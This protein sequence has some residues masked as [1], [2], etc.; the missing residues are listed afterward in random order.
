MQDQK[1]PCDIEAERAIL[2]AILV[3]PD[4]LHDVA[5]A[6]APGDFFRHGHR[7]VYDA[8]RE[9]AERRQA[10]DPLTVRAALSEKALEDAGGPIYIFGLA[11]GVP[12]STNVAAYCE[13]VKGAALR[14]RLQAIAT[15]AIAEAASSDIDAAAAVERAERA[16]YELGAKTQSGDLVP[17]EAAIAEVWPRIAEVV[18]T[19]RPQTGIPTGY[20]DLDRMTRGMF[21]G[22]LIILAARPGMGKSA[23]ALNVAHHVANTADQTVAFFSLEMSNDEISERLLGAVGRVN[24]HRVMGG[25][26][27]DEDLERLGLARGEAAASSLYIDDTSAQTVMSIRG[28]ARR[29][30]ARKGLGLVVVDYLQLLSSERRYDS[31]VVEVGAMSRGLK[32]LAGELEVPI[33]CLSQLNR[34]SEGRAESKPRISD[35]RE[36]G[37]LEQDANQVW[38]L[39]RPEAYQATPENTGLAELIVGKNRKGPTGTVTLRWAK[40]ETRFDSL[41]DR[42]E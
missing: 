25:R 28:K 42:G 1:T 23:L 34:A 2:G 16:I 27:F 14:R 15:A 7:I 21:P 24:M 20:P 29:L 33:L 13:I 3:N 17:I 4:L 40:D 19:G 38:L 36:S 12:R 6:I 11:D 35:L 32:Q 37:S 5:A 8:M 18:D 30:K 22:N 10:I 31:R 26:G 41:S 9:L 39:H